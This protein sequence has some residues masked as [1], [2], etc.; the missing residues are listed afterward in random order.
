MSELTR[1]IL[2]ATFGIPVLVITTYLGGWYFFAV[3][4]LISVVAQWEFY[5]MQLEKAIVPQSVT[6][7]IVGVALLTGIETRQWYA[8]GAVLV[9]GMMASMA[10]EMFRRHKNVSSNIGVTLLGLFYIPFFLG[11]LLYL[12]DLTDRLLPEIPR[13]GFRFVMMMFVTIWICDT[14]AYM[15]GKKIG[16]HKLYQKVS[17][18]KTVEGGIAGVIGSLLVLGI[19]KLSGILPLDW[20]QA[21][22]FGLVFG[23]IGQLGDLVESWFKRDVGVKDSSTLL[24]GHGGMLDRFD[25]IIFVSPVLLILIWTFWK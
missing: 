9:L 10:G 11:T 15:F 25:S 17:P 21:V 24:P 1:R 4:L 16:K 2:V 8:T 5:R 13:A 19:I 18:N 3:L 23:I 22:L 20:F 6:G 14:F 12:R 7:I